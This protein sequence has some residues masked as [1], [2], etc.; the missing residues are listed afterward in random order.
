MQKISINSIL[1][2][3]KAS[4]ES[5]SVQKIIDWVLHKAK[6]PKQ[7]WIISDRETWMTWMEV[8]KT[9]CNL[10]TSPIWLA[11]LR[12]EME[13]ISRFILISKTAVI[14]LFKK[15][16]QWE[17]FFSWDQFCFRCTTVKV[18]KFFEA[19][20]NSF[21]NRTVLMKETMEHCAKSELIWK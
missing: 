3:S 1:R 18:H 2:T 16:P 4:M 21:H 5:S 6:I 7:R 12:D 14:P 20:E 10:W 15:W 13:F 9:W 11:H 17:Q 19:A 8:I